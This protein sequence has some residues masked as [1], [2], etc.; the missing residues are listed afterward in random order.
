MIT[1]QAIKNTSK[2][3]VL[4]ALAAI[5]PGLVSVAHGNGLG[6]NGVGA[7]SMGLGGAS[8]ADESDALGAMAYNPAML[9]FFGKSQV[10]LGLNG[11][12]A[13][14]DYI[15]QAGDE[16][17][18]RDTDAVFPDLAMVF[19]LNEKLTMGVSV[20]PDDSRLANWRYVDPVG[21]AGVGYGLMKHRSEILNVR[22][23][24]GAG[25]RISDTVSLGVSVG[26][27]YNENHLNV[28]YIFQSHPALAG[29]KTLLDLGTTGW[30]INADVGLAWKVNENVTLGLGYRTPRISTPMV[31]VTETPPRSSLLSACLHRTAGSTTTLTSTR[32]SRKKS[33]A[34]S[35]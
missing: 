22:G 1:T 20:I 12:F 11:V 3:A 27:V 26:A 13:D 33:A 35:P 16:G 17:S 4:L 8:I 31:P 6:R 23:A 29:A 9:G 30:A 10:V 15:S 21:A 18:L 5:A 2:S 24:L 32:P 28:P 7:R 25:Y 14:G 34:A 19:P